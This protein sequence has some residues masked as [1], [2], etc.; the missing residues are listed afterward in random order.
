MKKEKAK[1]QMIILM[2]QT[3]NITP[4]YQCAQHFVASQN[5]HVV[6]TYFLWESDMFQLITWIIRVYDYRGLL[7]HA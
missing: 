1:Q 5:M 3:Y 2:S 7:F 4:R 6:R